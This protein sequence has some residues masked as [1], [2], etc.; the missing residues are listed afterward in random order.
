MNIWS[1]FSTSGKHDE[2]IAKGVDSGADSSALEIQS[3]SIGTFEEVRSDLEIDS[4]L[5]GGNQ[6]SSSYGRLCRG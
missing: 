6:E 5:E 4:I 1:F 2:E 3:K